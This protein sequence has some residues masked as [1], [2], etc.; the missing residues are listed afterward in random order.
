MEEEV[1]TA[2]VDALLL[3]AQLR[4]VDDDD[5]RLEALADLREHVDGVV[6]HVRSPD[7]DGDGG[8]VLRL[9]PLP[10]HEVRGV[11]AGA[12]RVAVA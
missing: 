8:H 7:L 10:A 1:L 6:Q 2:G 4:V 5:A 12:M 11:R 9:V 3:H